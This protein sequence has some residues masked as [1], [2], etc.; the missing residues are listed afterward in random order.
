M[1]FVCSCLL[2]ICTYSVRAGSSASKPS[3]QLR[4][5]A[6][7]RP[8]SG[9]NFSGI[10]PGAG[11]FVFLFVVVTC[12]FSSIFLQPCQTHQAPHCD[13]GRWLDRGFPFFLAHPTG[14]CDMPGPCLN[15]A[16]S[17]QPP[18]RY[19]RGEKTAPRNAPHHVSD[20]LAVSV[21]SSFLLA[22]QLLIII[23]RAHKPLCVIFITLSPENDKST[24]PLLLA[25][26]GWQLG[27]PFPTVSM[28]P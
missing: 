28:E 1:Y 19:A 4:S 7:S 23:A 13:F 8:T 21:F 3:K 11:F 12:L 18:N 2:H 24:T 25:S 26:F 27:A 20:A 9:R 15:L 17:D 16:I 10:F 5:R 6:S 22:I 14:G